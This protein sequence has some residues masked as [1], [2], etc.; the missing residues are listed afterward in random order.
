[1][2]DDE[3]SQARKTKDLRNTLKTIAKKIRKSHGFVFAVLAF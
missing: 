2:A 3:S 1:M